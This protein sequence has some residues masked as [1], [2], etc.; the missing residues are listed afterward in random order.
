MDRFIRESGRRSARR[1][2]LVGAS[3]FVLTLLVFSILSRLG[4]TY[5]FAEDEKASSLIQVTENKKLNGYLLSNGAETP[6]F[7]PKVV[8]ISTDEGVNKY[9]AYGATVKDILDELMYS[10]DEN[11]FPIPDYGHVVTDGSNIRIVRVDIKYFQ[12]TNVIPFAIKETKTEELNTGTVKVAQEGKNGSLLKT[13]QVKY[14]DG[15]AVKSTIVKS[16]ITLNPINKLVLIGTKPVTIQSCS[17][18]DKVIDRAVDPTTNKEKNQ[19]MKYVMRCETWCDSGQNTKDR[20]LGLYQFRKSTYAS[21]GG[22]NIWDGTE[23][24]Q[25]VSSMYEYGNDY[26]SLQWP[27][28]NARYNKAY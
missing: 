24:I 10:L 16:E 1:N 2:K 27:N 18:W 14:H 23:Q 9:L 12:K 25:I 3:F 20:F 13:V 7:A 15:I 8:T 4:N 17:Y 11:D 19:W 5:V 6:L 28:C 21:K 26:R 22:V